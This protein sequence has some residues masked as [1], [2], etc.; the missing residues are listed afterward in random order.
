M[1]FA[2]TQDMRSMEHMFNKIVTPS[3]VGKLK[4]LVIP[5]QLAEKYLPVVSSKNDKGLLLNFQDRNGKPWIFRYSYWNSSQ[6]YVMTKG[7]IR[8][9]KEKQLSA[10]DT[11]SFGRGVGGQ[12]ARDLLY[13]D[14][15][16][17]PETRTTTPTSRQLQTTYINSMPVLEPWN[18]HL[19]QIQTPHRPYNVNNG[20]GY[21]YSNTNSFL[22]FASSVAGAS[23]THSNLGTGVREDAIV[24]ESAPSSK[25]ITKFVRLFGVNLDCPSSSSSSSST[26]AVS[27]QLSLGDSGT[28]TSG[29]WYDRSN[30]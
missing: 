26:P 22:Y 23:P 19:R 16:R 2:A 7:W 14:W 5:K 30:T 17:G 28:S 11:V 27:L 15:N 21:G 4:W 20:C 8:F 1:E 12:A 9:V 29:A 6:T 10:G 24:F 13:I 3:D 18:D 25:N